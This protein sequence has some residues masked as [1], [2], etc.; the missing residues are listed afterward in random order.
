[1][2]K[3]HP[4]D[5]QGIMLRLLREQGLESPLQQKRLTDNWDTVAGPAVARLTTAK[6]IRNQTLFVRVASP[7]LRA[8]LSMMRSRLVRL[9]NESVGAQVIV[10]LRLV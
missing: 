3:H 6:Y 9:L 1:M 5:I 2:F 10:D 8:D 4:E 7:A